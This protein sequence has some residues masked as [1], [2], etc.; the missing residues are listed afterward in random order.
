MQQAVGG[1][2]CER[3]GTFDSF[4]VK[5]EIFTFRLP[6]KLPHFP[7]FACSGRA[8][9]ERVVL[10]DALVVGWPGRRKETVESASRKERNE[11]MTH[12]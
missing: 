9:D 5:K 10:L 2:L 3:H 6:Q 11:W 7:I 8:L 12:L 4:R 1:P